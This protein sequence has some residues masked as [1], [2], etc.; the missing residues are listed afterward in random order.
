MVP[1]LN[2]DRLR[3]PKSDTLTPLKAMTL[4]WGVSKDEAVLPQIV[5]RTEK[6]VLSTRVS[7]LVVWFARRLGCDLG[8][9][10]DFF[11]DTDH[12]N[13]RIFVYCL[14]RGDV[15]EVVLDLWNIA[16]VFRLFVCQYL[17]LIHI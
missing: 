10:S 6:P 17:S 14:Q 9:F 2:S 4:S 15:G 5:R 8:D 11:Q 7:S 3:P 13:G 16:L 1:E 12:V